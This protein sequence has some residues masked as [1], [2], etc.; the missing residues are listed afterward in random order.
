MSTVDV[1]VVGAGLSGLVA[2]YR[3][4]QADADVVVLE[5]K[6]RVGG[7]LLTSPTAAGAG[8]DS[9][10]SWV[11][12]GQHA[13][14]GLLDELGIG[15][16]PQFADGVNLL[17]V[18]GRTHRYRGDIPRLR[19]HEMLDLGRAQWA[20]DRIARR[21]GAPPWP[22]ALAARLDEQT[23]GSWMRRKVR[24][25]AAR[26]VLDTATA[27]SFGCRPSELS[28]LG[29]ASQVGGCGGLADLIGVR[30]G[31][32]ASRIAGGAAA[33]P[34]E[35]ARRL[36]ERVRLGHAVTEIRR[37]AG[38]ITLVGHDHPPVYARR[39]IVAVDPAT[40]GSIT[41][42]PPLPVERAELQRRWQMGS[43]IKAH[44]V[45]RRP[46]WRDHGLTGATVT[47]TGTVRLTFD[48]SPAD[49]PG[50]LV[51]FLGLPAGD[52]PELLS[53][54]RSAARRRQVLDDLAT[55]LGPEARDAVDYVE[56]D[57]TAEP[58]QSGCVPRPPAGVLHPGHRWLTRPVDGLHWAGAESSYLGEAHMDGAVRAG[59]RAAGEAVT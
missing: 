30:D 41:H 11:G 6:N 59:E 55:L 40:A 54:D 53:S 19:P 14:L 50:V 20:L 58:W 4:R 9:G 31:A 42:D 46:W 18:R 5:A 8:V 29:F 38:L 1:A 37:S 49:G 26:L 32:L 2:A 23:L 21:L 10:G 47:D 57:W 28:L 43:G 27:A 24:T 7:R 34:A 17:R 3:L 22:P 39:V 15:L 51:T 35:L 13:V 36:G 48:V 44:V 33:L 52:T 45:Y 12:P 25:A 16:V 56:Q